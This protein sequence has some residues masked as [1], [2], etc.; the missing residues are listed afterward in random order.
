MPKA[1]KP[2]VPQ[3]PSAGYRLKIRAIVLTVRWMN[4]FLDNARVMDALADAAIIADEYGPY[5]FPRLREW[6]INAWYRRP[7][8][9]RFSTLD[10][11]YERGAIS[12]LTRDMP[13]NVVELS[14][15]LTEGHASRITETGKVLVAVR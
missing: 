3:A 1:T 4:R 13:F 15:D 14:Y 7:V 12:A 10:E 5:C 9:T 8:I 11:R 2:A 6:L